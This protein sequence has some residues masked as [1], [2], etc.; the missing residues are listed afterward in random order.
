VRLEAP[1]TLALHALYP[2]PTRAEA[3]LRYALPTAMDVEISVYNV[4]GQRVATLA[5]GG[6][7]AGRVEP[8]L[9]HL[10]DYNVERTLFR[11]SVG[12]DSPLVGT[13]LPEAFSGEESS[14]VELSQ[15]HRDGEAYL[16]LPLIYIPRCR[17]PLP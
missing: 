2:N 5:N 16:A 6:Q 10:E 1:T 7:A 12:K 3:T 17:L 14:D 11:F 9:E 15:F 8:R 4:L 13:P